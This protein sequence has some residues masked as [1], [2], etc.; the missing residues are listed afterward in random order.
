MRAG[1]RRLA[2]VAAAFAAATV[3]SACASR[4]GPA[5]ACCHQEW[6]PA[7]VE[8]RFRYERVPAECRVREMGRYAVR[9][10]PI[11][12]TREAPVTV[13][14]EVAD[15]CEVLVPVYERA[16]LPVYGYR[17]VEDR[18]DRLCPTYGPGCVPNTCKQVTVCLGVNLNPCA[19]PP[20]R[21]GVKVEDV[22]RGT[23]PGI[24]QTGVHVESV[25]CGEHQERVVVGQKPGCV[26]TGARLG[27]VV[28]GS[29]YE[30]IQVG[31][32]CVSDVVG[33]DT[34]IVRTGTRRE[35]VLVRPSRIEAVPEPVNIPGYCVW[36]CDTGTHAG[37]DVLTRAEFEA[38]RAGRGR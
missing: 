4:R 23:K 26:Q 19:G 35:T 6:V 17:T 7:R 31:T 18:K 27:T 38:L 15:T 24:V 13:P 34:R 12:H 3:L 9:S 29:H 32:E 22:V 16:C 28:T 30:P 1:F 33:Y 11:V 8:T 36:V 14:I 10:E 25:R 21:A 20:I 5:G 37:G 2:V